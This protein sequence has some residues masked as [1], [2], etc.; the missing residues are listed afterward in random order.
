VACHG[1]YGKVNQIKDDEIENEIKRNDSEYCMLRMSYTIKYF[2][3]EC[4]V[5]FGYST[6]PLR[7]YLRSEARGAGL[8]IK[9]LGVD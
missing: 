6:I 7:L 1:S 9:E 5:E 2:Q 3:M 8:G 4:C